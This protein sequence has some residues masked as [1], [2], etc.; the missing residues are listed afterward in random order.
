M[1][2]QV[3]IDNC[4]PTLAGIK[5][6]SLVNVC[7]GSRER[8]DDDIRRLN[9]ECFVCRGLRAVPLRYSED[10]AVL[11]LIYRPAALEKLLQDTKVRAYLEGLGYPC[12]SIA[13]CI[14]Q[15]AGRITRTETFPHE[16]GIF[17][18]YPLEDVI[19]FTEHKDTGCKCTGYW[20]V[21]GDEAAARRTFE[22]YRRCTACYRR[23]WQCGASLTS[24]T[25]RL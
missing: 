6:A 15:L 5:P 24:L 22:R 4:S 20:K 21:Y 11:L 1:P 8:A 12:E 25:V 23:S 18:G 17:L 16:I 7:C 19:G 2:E 9:R 10:G 3:L 14:A 13:H